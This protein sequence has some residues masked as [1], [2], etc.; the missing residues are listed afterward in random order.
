MHSCIMIC[1]VA[2]KAR[3][4]KLAIFGKVRGRR[5]A[6]K[7]Y[8]FLFEEGLSIFKGFVSKC[9]AFFQWMRF[10]M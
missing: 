6:L 2:L 5:T 8:S 1:A 3:H 10:V 9:P 4:K 7:T